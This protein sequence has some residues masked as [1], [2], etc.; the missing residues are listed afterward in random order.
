[1][2]EAR[3]SADE[4]EIKNKNRTAFFAGHERINKSSLTN[5]ALKLD[6]TIDT[7]IKRDIIFFGCIGFNAFDQLSAF[8]VLKAQKENPAIKL[9]M[10]LPFEKQYSLFSGAD[11]K[12]YRDILNSTNKVVYVS[13]KNVSGCIEKRNH[14]L[15]KHSSVHLLRKCAL[16]AAD[17]FPLPGI[18]VAY[19]KYEQSGTGQ[20]VKL[21]QENGL[22]IIN[23]HE[24]GAMA[25][26]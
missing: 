5:L 11:S 13:E 14:H 10:I 26:G 19:M 9:I 24:A 7:L 8:A 4:T 21:S 20:I 6:K 16:R 15:I 23:L 25:K 18:C 1:M 22:T 12:T 3:K 17:F 2:I